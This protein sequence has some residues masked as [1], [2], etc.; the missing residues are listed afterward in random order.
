MKYRIK[1]VKINDFE[2]KYY[3]Q[4]YVNILP[5]GF[6]QCKNWFFNIK[7]AERYID[8]LIEESKLDTS[9]INYPKNQ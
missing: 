4:E 6:W 1:V 2:C 5:M 9:F 3:P 8:M 7:D